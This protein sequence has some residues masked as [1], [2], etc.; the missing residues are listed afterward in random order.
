[1]EAMDNFLAPMK[2]TVPEKRLVLFGNSSY[3]RIKE[4]Q[5]EVQADLLMLAG[6]D[7]TIAERLFLGSNTDYLLHNID[8]KMYV[9][10]C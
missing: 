4:Y 6:H 5:K 7:H 8:V 9:F 10:K 3:S 2:I 1:M